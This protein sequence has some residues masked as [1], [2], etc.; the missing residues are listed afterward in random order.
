MSD[1]IIYSNLQTKGE[2]LFVCNG[3]ICN[4]VAKNLCQLTPTN[5]CW[6][7]DTDQIQATSPGINC[8]EVSKAMVGS[9]SSYSYV[10]ICCDINA[11]I[12]GFSQTF[13]N[14][15]NVS[16]YNGTGYGDCQYLMQ[17][18]SPAG[19]GDYCDRLNVLYNL[20]DLASC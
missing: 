14:E 6:K 11:N 18:Y 9:D 5:T 7:Y 8:P 16:S 19:S 3:G 15:N 17:Q 1:E 20:A 10:I 4:E 12:W 13:L 2:T